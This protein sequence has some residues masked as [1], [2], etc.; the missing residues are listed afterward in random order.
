MAIAEERLIKDLVARLSSDVM[1]PPSFDNRERRL[2]LQRT[3]HSLVEL[4]SR[5]L[6]IIAQG[7]AMTLDGILKKATSSSSD[8]NPDVQR[9]L[10][11]V[12]SLLVNCLRYQWDHIK[13]EYQNVEGLDETEQIRLKEKEETILPPSLD[14]HLARDLLR[15]VV[16]I[17]KIPNAS[18]ALQRVA[19]R[20]LFQLSATNYDAVISLVSFSSAT[21]SEEE[22]ATQFQL[23]EYLNLNSRR[24]AE[25]LQKMNQV[26]PLLKKDAQRFGVAKVLRTAIWNWID[27]YPMEFVSLCQSGHRLPGGPE[28]L[29]DVFD[30]W[31]SKHS[32]RRMNY[33]P[34]QTM[35]LILCPDIM[36]KVSLN[37]KKKP[38][39]AKV[40]KTC[41][42]VCVSCFCDVCLCWVHL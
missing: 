40:R 14:E 28:V 15:M 9:S 22:L 10:V 42:C 7:L 34:L 11:S 13:S 33:W 27:N 41:V 4:S 32:G 6:P 21:T 26:V 31:A 30:G 2:M 12:I 18:P 20:C 35:L 19:G 25:L 36:L 16:I 1:Q 29:F 3:E 24:L 39:D 17:F 23:M 8:A 5:K 37:D 38:K